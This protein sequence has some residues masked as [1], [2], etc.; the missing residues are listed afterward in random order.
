[1]Y[2]VLEAQTNNTTATA[3]YTYNTKEEALSKYYNILSYAVLSDIPIHTAF[4][5]SDTGYDMDSRC[6]L[7]N[8]E[9][10]DIN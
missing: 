4:I 3:V 9:L 7:H 10:E 8:I 2:I 5:L 6:F 1:M